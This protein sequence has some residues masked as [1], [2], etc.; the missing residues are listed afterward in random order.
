MDHLSDRT[1]LALIRLAGRIGV[2]AYDVILRYLN[3][4]AN[5]EMIGDTYTVA[6]LAAA[7]R[8]YRRSGIAAHA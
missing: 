6:D 3:L 7:Y 2:P 4:R 8:A 5:A 1:R